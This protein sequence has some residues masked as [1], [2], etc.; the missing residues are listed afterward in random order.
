MAVSLYFEQ[1][2]SPYPTPVK[3]RVTGIIKS[4]EIE[5]ESTF[6]FRDAMILES[7]LF[8]PIPT[9]VYNNY[10]VL[11]RPYIKTRI[12]ELPSRAK[13]GGVSG[14]YN[15]GD[16]A[17][18]TDGCILYNSFINFEKQG[19][20]YTSVYAP[21]GSPPAFPLENPALAFKVDGFILNAGLNGF[22][23]SNLGPGIANATDI[24]IKPNPG[25]AM[26]LYLA[27][28]CFFVGS[29]G[30]PDPLPIDLYAFLAT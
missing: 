10:F 30:T 22:S 14:K 18:F 6:S 23:P 20:M 26:T 1:T 17:Y 7:V 27:Y 5:E 28:T 21:N 15:L 13:Y 8:A 25:T 29:P 16:L 19:F 24:I 9:L 3:T 4:I 12:I 2:I 11:I